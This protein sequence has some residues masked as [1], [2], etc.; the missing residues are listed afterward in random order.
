MVRLNGKEYVYQPGMSLKN[1]VD[2]YNADN[3]K[4]LAFDGFVVLVNSRAL[5][6]TQANERL[7]Q[8]NDNILI[9]PFLGGG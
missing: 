6:A 2:H 9:T 5:T 4:E 8:D 1:F 7:L 3:H